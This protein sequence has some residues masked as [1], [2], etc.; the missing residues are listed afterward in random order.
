MESPTGSS[1]CGTPSP[2]ESANSKATFDRWEQVGTVFK[3]YVVEWSIFRHFSFLQMA[4][5][6]ASRVGHLWQFHR[7]RWNFG[8]WCG[9]ACS[10]HKHVIPF[11][12][13]DLAR[14]SKP[15]LRFLLQKVQYLPCSKW[16]KVASNTFL[17]FF[18]DSDFLSYNILTSFVESFQVGIVH[19]W[20]RW[21]GSKRRFT[22]CEIL[23]LDILEGVA[24]RGSLKV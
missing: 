16:H 10:G 7:G 4:H 13:F 24:P 1:F 19:Q 11:T 18:V 3:S 15:I 20:V 5:Q 14:P 22:S 2:K 8:S 17:Y 21:P 9:D 23:D 6:W 12:A